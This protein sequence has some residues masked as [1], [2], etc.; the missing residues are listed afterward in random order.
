MDEPLAAAGAGAE[1]ALDAGRPCS[2]AITFGGGLPGG[3][4]EVSVEK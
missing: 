1:A 3:V 2:D 4:V